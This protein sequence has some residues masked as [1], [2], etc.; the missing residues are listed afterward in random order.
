MVSSKVR[1][2][3]L[4]KL[5]SPSSPLK[6]VSKG[7]GPAAETSTISAANAQDSSTDARCVLCF[8]YPVTFFFLVS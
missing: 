3:P 4:F 6:K 1:A 7:T 2:F 5:H 8:S